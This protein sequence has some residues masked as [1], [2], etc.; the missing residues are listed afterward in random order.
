MA[1]LLVVVQCVYQKLSL[2]KIVHVA[3]VAVVVAAA[4]ADFVAVAEV[5]AVAVAAD[6]AAAAEVHAV[7]VDRVT[8]VADTV[9][10]AE[11]VTS[12]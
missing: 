7:V 10:A 8:A 12:F 5:H 1:K 2:K 9:A 3:Q 6:T 4:A 11:T